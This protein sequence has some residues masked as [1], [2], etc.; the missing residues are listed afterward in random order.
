M[1]KYLFLLIIALIPYH[2]YAQ[3][4]IKIK[5]TKPTFSKY[6]TKSFSKTKL[7]LQ[8]PELIKD[9]L[10]SFTKS[11]V[12]QLN[13]LETN[14]QF[15]EQFQY[16]RSRIHNVMLGLG[17]Y[18]HYKNDFQFISTNAYKIQLGF[19]LV[20]QS[21]LYNGHSPDLHFSINA[22]IEKPL[23]SWLSIYAYGQYLSPN[24]SQNPNKIDP[25]THMNPLFIQSEAGYGL[26]AKYRNIEADLGSKTM[27]DTQFKKSKPMPMMNSKVKIG[28]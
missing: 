22:G 13:I 3:E 10:F 2:L 18:E 12:Y 11:G 9:D 20:K 28:F 21:S 17:S 19:G 4:G 15:H 24:F 26:R 5:L 8:K 16:T 23:T 25:I 14:D 6:E 7:A 1:I 27:F